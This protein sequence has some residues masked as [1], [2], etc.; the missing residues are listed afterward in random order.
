MAGH[1][2]DYKKYLLSVYGYN[3]QYDNW[4]II[5]YFK[6]SI[7]ANIYSRIKQEISEIDLDKAEIVVYVRLEGEEPSYNQEF[8]TRIKKKAWLISGNEIFR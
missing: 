7:P 6:K 5:Y 4:F 2:K 8:N 1:V 3:D